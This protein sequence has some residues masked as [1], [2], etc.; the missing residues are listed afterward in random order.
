MAAVRRIV[1]MHALMNRSHVTFR[2]L[3]GTRKIF[4]LYVPFDN[5]F[6]KLSTVFHGKIGLSAHARILF[7][8][9]GYTCDDL[10]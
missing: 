9:N 4:N 5:I 10:T 7:F 2:G 8:Q 6:Q 3:R 1:S